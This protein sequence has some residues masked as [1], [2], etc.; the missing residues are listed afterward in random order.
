MTEFATLEELKE[1]SDWILEADQ[2]RFSSGTIREIERL[3][4]AYIAAPEPFYIAWLGG[5]GLKEKAQIR[6]D[7]Y[8]N[9][10]D[11]KLPS[12][13]KIP[14][15]VAYYLAESEES[16]NAAKT[17]FEKEAG[18]STKV[19]GV[20]ASALHFVV[21]PSLYS[22]GSAAQNWIS[23]ANA[24][25]EV[26]E[27]VDKLMAQRDQMVP[28]ILSRYK[29]VAEKDKEFFL[30]RGMWKTETVRTQGGSMSYSIYAP[31][32]KNFGIDSSINLEELRRGV[33]R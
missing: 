33:P 32:Y 12:E 18:L 9:V 24:T 27:K 19:Y 31:V 6:A 7:Y 5:A 25:Q 11:G 14:P 23:F 16:F 3:Q 10:T 17:S 15:L 2:N 4:N 30:R 26:T 20:L 13:L 8:N 29:L 28:A 1:I 22:G 21:A